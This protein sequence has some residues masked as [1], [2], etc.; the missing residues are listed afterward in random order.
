MNSMDQ[1]EE[2][3]ICLDKALNIHRTTADIQAE[4]VDWLIKGI[5]ESP[6]NPDRARS[7]FECALRI[8]ED[9]GDIR[10]ER[11][12]YAY[13]DDLRERLHH[14]KQTRAGGIFPL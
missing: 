2:A 10:L 8:S 11:K 4:A 3:V 14:K 9:I 12:T 6:R 13:L 1:K 5:I 7:Y